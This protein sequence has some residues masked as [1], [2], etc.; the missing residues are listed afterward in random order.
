[1][2]D[3]LQLSGPV[4]TKVEENNDV[5]PSASIVATCG[6]WPEATDGENAERDPDPDDDEEGATVRFDVPP[7]LDV[8]F[9]WESGSSAIHERVP[10]P[11]AG[12]GSQ[13][14]QLDASVLVVTPRTFP[15]I[16]EVLERTRTPPSMM[17]PRLVRIHS[18][19]KCHPP[20]ASGRR[21]AYVSV[22]GRVATP[23]PATWKPPPPCQIGLGIHVEAEDKNAGNGLRDKLRG[24]VQRVR[25]KGPEA[26][27]G[28]RRR[29][30][31][32]RGLMGETETAGRGMWKDIAV[33]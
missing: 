1:M 4:S 17:R 15:G 14:V 28:Q 30:K 12:C 27:P 2:I 11:H 5:S 20:K 25:R 26:R 33:A 8:T 10:T 19:V 23:P 29:I 24:L 6:V 16:L 7:T 9:P 32:L 18:V 21:K 13:S 31:L 3:F 22:V